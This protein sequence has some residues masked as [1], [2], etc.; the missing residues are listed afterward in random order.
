MKVCIFTVALKI[1]LKNL[2]FDSN[3]ETK[4]QEGFD[5]NCKLG[6]IELSYNERGYSEH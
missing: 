1:S 2:L 3:N 6:Y 4:M 5:F